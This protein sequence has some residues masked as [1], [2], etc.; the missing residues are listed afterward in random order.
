MICQSNVLSSPPNVLVKAVLLRFL[1]V[2]L[3]LSIIEF[4]F[5]NKSTIYVGG[6][7]LH[8]TVGSGG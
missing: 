8:R 1:F 6:L 7:H 5:H 3:I 2:S 4:M